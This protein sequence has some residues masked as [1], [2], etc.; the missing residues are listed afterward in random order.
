MHGAVGVKVDYKC[1]KDIGGGEKTI[2][3][4]KGGGDG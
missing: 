3:A 1:A 4:C 2:V